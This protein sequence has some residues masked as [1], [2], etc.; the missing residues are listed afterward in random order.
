MPAADELLAGKSIGGS[1]VLAY[2]DMD[3]WMAT[4]ADRKVTDAELLHHAESWGAIEELRRGGGTV[5]APLSKGSY[6]P[7][8][9]AAEGAQEGLMRNETQ[10][11]LELLSGGTFSDKTLSRHAVSFVAGGYRDLIGTSWLAVLNASVTA[12]SP[13]WLHHFHMGVIYLERTLVPGD[14][15]CTAAKTAFMA[16]LAL[17][18]TPE[19]LRNLAI[20]AHSEEKHNLAFESYFEALTLL[21]VAGDSD[22]DPVG[23]RLLVRDLAAEAAY[24]FAMIEWTN[25]TINLTAVDSVVPSYARTT[26]RFR[27]GEVQAAMGRSDYDTVF[28]LLDCAPARL[29]PSLGWWGG[30]T[31]QLGQWYMAAKMATALAANGNMTLTTLERNAVYRQNP[32]P[33]CIRAAGH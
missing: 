30:G 24:Q 15:N 13:T 14:G 6:F 7:P 25:C 17:K 31:L 27:F 12:H 9:T 19:A 4:L 29:W 16:S 28:Q 21:L 33:F 10:P 22:P 3:A 26:D 18:R 2:E 8:L 32:V 1:D 20:I 5:A 23:G 11:F